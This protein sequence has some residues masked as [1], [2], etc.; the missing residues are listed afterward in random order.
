MV[1]RL[2]M[3]KN[4]GL[5]ILFIALILA[6]SMRNNNCQKVT[7]EPYKQN[8]MVDGCVMQKLGDNWIRT[9]G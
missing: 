7:I 3:Y 9:C 4:I 8:Q 2:K 6:F 1:W 5:G